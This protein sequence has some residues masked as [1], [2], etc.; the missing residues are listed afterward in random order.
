M[1]KKSHFTL[2]ILLALANFSFAQ[3]T[4]RVVG[5]ITTWSNIN[6]TINSIDWDKFSHINVSF[7]NPVNTNG[8][9]DDGTS[10]AIINRLIDSAHAHNVKVLI[11]LGGAIQ[12]GTTTRT[13][14]DHLLQTGNR[15]K[16]INGI[17]AFVDKYNYDGVDVDLEGELVNAYYEGFI[18]DLAAEF[19]PEG[20]LLTAALARWNGNSVSDVALQHFDFVN[21]MAYDATGP[22]SGPG[23]HSTVSFARNNINYWLGRDVPAEDLV[24][25]VPFYGYD[26]DD[27]GRAWTYRAIVETF[28][29]AEDK[30]RVNNLYYN[31]Q[32]TIKEKT[33]IG[34]NEI[35]GIMIWEISQDI[36]DT[37]SRSLLSTIY[38]TIIQNNGVIGSGNNKPIVLI[39]SPT[40]NSSIQTGQ[41][42]LVVVDAQDSDGSIKSVEL[43]YD[44]TSLNKLTSAPYE[45]TLQ[46]LTKGQHTLEAEAIDNNDA[47][48]KSS[49]IINVTVPQASFEGKITELPGILEAEN[50]DVG[51]QG[52]SYFDVDAAN[53]GDGY[54]DE[55]VD[56]EVG[57]SVTNVGYIAQGEWLE[58]TVDVTDESHYDINCFVASNGFKGEMIFYLDGE[59]ITKSE[60]M[61]NTN[62]W[63]TWKEKKI[64]TTKELTEGEHILRVEFEKGEFNIDKF[65]FTQNKSVGLEEK[66]Y[67]TTSLY[68]NP[69]SETLYL[70]K[71]EIS[72]N[73]LLEVTNVFGEKKITTRGKAKVT[74][75]SFETL[76]QGVYYVTL[77][78]TEN[79]LSL[80]YP[81]IKQ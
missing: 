70:N 71:G 6:G 16:L 73:L 14:W 44:G 36:S 47:S 76:P 52:V 69:V 33:E 67:A 3:K 8:L 31:G 27:N 60:E 10:D 20:T 25:G 49:I 57:S 12:P 28:E 61:L 48:R 32:P 1:I 58:Y 64:T 72:E 66:Y 24:L 51:G 30:D 37:D 45:F 23:P 7:G 21:M 17:R 11:S 35:G 40:N 78:S 42:L 63:T 55:A 26:F 54:R 34:V 75:I 65:E 59:P 50:F 5:Y 77:I 80:T 74:K 43:F 79:Q 4:T 53:R 39:T 38:N 56:I 68:P 18:V 22:W 81:I 15:S 19:K 46:N 29:G 2:F 13:Y 9:F 62:G 41:D